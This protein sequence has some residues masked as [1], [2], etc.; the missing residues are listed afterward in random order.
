VLAD[1]SIARVRELGLPEQR[2]RT[3]VELARA[4]V[5]GRV[6]LAPG[7]DPEAFMDAL[8][9]VVGIGPWTA[10]YLAMRVLRWPN[11]F[12]SGDLAIR[13]ALRVTTAGAAEACAESWQPWRA[14]G[15]LHLWNA[16]SQGG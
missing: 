14:Y 13:Q 6:E 15:A 10:H 7:T 8:R 12:P 3:L 11:A 9:S 4:V 5:Q 2:A 16:L 1:A